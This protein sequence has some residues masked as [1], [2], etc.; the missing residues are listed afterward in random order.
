[1]KKRS[2]SRG[3]TRVGVNGIV[4]WNGSRNDQVSE[5]WEL[6]NLVEDGWAWQ[7]PGWEWV[8]KTLNRW[9][10]NNRTASSCRA[11][12]FRVNPPNKESSNREATE[13]NS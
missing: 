9:H 10:K 8:A 6:C 2:E 5:V 13:R 3:V 11:K 12:Y 7:W 1:M 4:R